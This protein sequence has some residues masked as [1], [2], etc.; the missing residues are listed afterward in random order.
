M[1]KSQTTNGLGRVHVEVRN[2]FGIPDCPPNF[3]P[4]DHARIRVEANMEE[5]PIA[6]ELVMLV[7][8]PH[9]IGANSDKCSPL[10]LLV[11]PCLNSIWLSQL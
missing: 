11:A 4:M 5:K 7:E 9:L 1:I 3:T 8:A 2:K 10:E 6:L